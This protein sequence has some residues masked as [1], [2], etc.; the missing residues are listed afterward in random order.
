VSDGAP[1]QILTGHTLNVWSVAFSPDGQRIASGSFDKTAK[2]WRA[3]SGALIQTLTAHAQAVVGVAFSPD[4]QLLATSG[5]D[6]TVRLWRVNDGTLLRTISADNHIYKV[7]FSRDGQWLAGAGRE[8][9]ALGTLWKKLT[10]KWLKGEKG[11]TVRLWRVS[12][13]SLQ[14][15]LT[16]HDV[17][18]GSVAFSPDGNWLASGSEDRTVK[19]WRLEKTSAP[20]PN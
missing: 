6:S 19:L 1:L 4:G 2:L 13:G 10:G 17:N 14:Q 16:G 18:A 7:A 15:E 20:R 9:G 8:H 3:D 11:T 5:D 12:D